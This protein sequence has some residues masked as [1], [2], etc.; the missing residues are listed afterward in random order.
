MAHKMT[1]FFDFADAHA[2]WSES[3]YLQTGQAQDMQAHALKVAKQRT[4]FLSARVQ[5]TDVRLHAPGPP[6]DVIYVDLGS[7]NG[8]VG[9]QPFAESSGS[10]SGAPEDAFT[11]LL[12]SLTGTEGHTRQLYLRGVSDEYIT[13]SRVTPFLW[14]KLDVQLKAYFK[15]L[16]DEG[17]QLLT[18]SA[19]ATKQNG[20]W[21]Q[22][23]ITGDWVMEDEDLGAA[24]GPGV[25][26]TLA[27]VKSNPLFNGKWQVRKFP[28]DAGKTWG[29]FVG[30]HRYGR[31][32]NRDGLWK[33]KTG[34]LETIASGQFIRIV[35]KKSG[36][37]FGVPRGR[38]SAKI[39]HH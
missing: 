28:G 33:T 11:A 30:S 17:M 24:A 20:L 1:M 32:A 25:T 38:Q 26:I 12:C 16:R 29:V 37:F 6:R 15:K 35:E 5:I 22:D 19:T 21:S 39:L 18:F 7:P 23:L 8:L 34:V 31:P 27:R 36:R 14:G 9:Q 2:G 3:F 10:S 13:G 4:T